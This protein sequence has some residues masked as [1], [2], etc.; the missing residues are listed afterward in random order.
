MVSA[1]QTT[2][3]GNGTTEDPLRMVVSASLFQ[4]TYVAAGGALP[5]VPGLPVVV[6]SAV[7][8]FGIASVTSGSSSVGGAADVVAVITRLADG[9]SVLGV[10][11]RGAGPVVLTT[12]QW[13]VVTGLTGGLSPNVEYYLGED[14]G[15]TATPPTAPGTLLSRVGI[16]V[17]AIALLLTTP[18]DP[19][20][21]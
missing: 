4:A 2:I 17:S 20:T 18:S 15:L 12:A 9:G 1:D 6:D 8:V 5:P 11:L 19:I 10:V 16:A 14:G 7:P 3:L 13:D 21:N